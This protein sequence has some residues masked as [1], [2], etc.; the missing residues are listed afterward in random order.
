MLV[1]FFLH[2]YNIFKRD[3]TYKVCVFLCVCV[4][5]FLLRRFF[6]GFSEALE[7]GEREETDFSCIFK[8]VAP[9]TNVVTMLHS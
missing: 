8:V 2:R 7:S 5:P 3:F 6:N 4:C 1:F 9:F